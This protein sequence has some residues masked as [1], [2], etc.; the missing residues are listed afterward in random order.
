MGSERHPPNASYVG[1]M[2]LRLLSTCAEL[3]HTAV[4]TAFADILT[5][6]HRE[7]WP[8]RSRRFKGFLRRSYY[9]ATGTAPSALV[10]KMALD[11]LEARAQFDA[12]ERSVHLR[13][14]EHQ[15][16]LYLD[17]ANAHWQAVE[18]ASS[19]WRVIDKPPVRFRRPPGLLPLPLPKRGGSLDPLRHLLN[20]PNDDDFVLVIAWLLAALRPNGPYP[21]LAVS[22]EQGSAKTVLCKLLK[23]LIDP[24]VAPVRAL[25][26]EERELMIAATNS[27]VLAFDNVSGLPGWLSDALCRIA[28]GGSLTVRQ[29][30]TDDE[31]VLFQAARPTLLNGIEDVIARPDLA[32]R[33]IFLTLAPIGDRK[34]Q[35]EAK[36][37][38][39]FD[40]A[41]PVILGALLDLAAHGLKLRQRIGHESLPRM[42]DFVVWGTA[43]ETALWPAGT[44]AHAYAANRRA[45]IED[46]IEADPVAACVREIMTSRDKWSGTAS[47]FLLIAD[48]L[49]REKVS[50]SRPDWPRTPRALAGRLRRAQT[51][52][53]AV[54]ID[55]AFLREG[56]A[57]N[58]MIRMRANAVNT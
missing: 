12:P 15:G 36:L 43:C 53:R 42:A 32:D 16:R 56:H 26:R 17:L 2:D 57:G 25:A 38:R 29:L 21:L 4:G 6:G 33:A 23:A 46:V 31:E 30:Y 49:Q 44:I 40:R 18:I 9:K 28:S 47:D 20:L 50:I 5:D 27:H 11:Q 8:I 14:A 34:R 48:K 24:N 3:F 1:A 13:V 37:W 35:P 52:L 19:G 41:R 10:I 22:G 7:T 45:A 39:D 54:G 51:S 58:R 55:L